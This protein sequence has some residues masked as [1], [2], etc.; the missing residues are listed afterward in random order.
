MEKFLYGNKVLV[1]GA[2]SGIGRET[3]LLLSSLGY[4]VYGVSRSAEEKVVENGKGIIHYMAMDVRKDEDIER[5][6]ST[7]G[8]FSF[9]VHAAGFGIG[10]AAEDAELDDIKAQEDTDYLGVL[11]LNR[12]ALPIL[13]RSERSLVIA[14]SSVAARV[15]LPYQSHYSA[16]KASL[17]MVM[18]AL[19]ME[20]AEYGVRVSLVEPGDMATG[21]TDKRKASVPPSSIYGEKYRRTL[22]VIEKDERGGGS[23]RA[24]AKVIER[25]SRRS[26]PPI[27]VTVGLTYKILV[28]LIKVLPD[29]LTLFILKKIYKV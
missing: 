21:F 18:M 6:L 25:I 14:V 17:E 12:K 23:P 24:A 1:T 26:N 8:D 9:L 13:R 27:R 4:T 29:R 11:R 2:T 16:A 28:L 10:G 15:P 5:V 7:I 22:S 3:A 19:R 20:S